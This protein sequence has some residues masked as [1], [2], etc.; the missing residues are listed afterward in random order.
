MHANITVPT[1]SFS[2]PATYPVLYPAT[3]LL[4]FISDAL[5]SCLSPIVV[6]WVLSMIFHYIDEYELLEKYRIHTPEEVLKRNHVSRYEVIRDVIIQQVIQFGFGWILGYIEPEEMTGAESWEIYEL[7]QTV[8]WSTSL[9]LGLSG[10][11]AGTLSS[12][13]ASYLSTQ[14]SMGVFLVNVDWRWKIAE[15][16]YWVL[17]PLLRLG[18]AIFILD[19]WQYFWHR[20]MHQVPFLYRTLHS[21]HHRLYVP[22]AF[23]ALYNHPLEGLILDTMGAG[24]AFKVSGMSMKGSVFFFGFSAMKTVD[25]HCGYKLPFDPLQII[26]SNNAEYH[27][28]HHQGWGIKHNFSQPFLIC[29]DRWLGTIY[30]GGD[31]AE[32]NRRTQERVH[33]QV[34]AEKSK[35]ASINTPSE[36]DEYA[37]R[38]VL[39]EEDDAEFIKT[40]IVAKLEST[41]ATEPPRQRRRTRTITLADVAGKDMAE[42]VKEAGE[43]VNGVVGN[44]SGAKVR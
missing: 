21:R 39:P 31:A 28:I 7:S 44:V 32:R 18:L 33:R 19:T 42:S 8:G 5:L 38:R 1:S 37:A 2:S 20:L 3:P 35:K 30:T 36:Q 17:F 40:S 23:G 25:D 24:L 22:Y 29:W 13:V 9:L 4:P 12:N 14:G 6:Y 16:L 15:T 26:F 41:T 34:E 43:W 27:D 10:I 11:D